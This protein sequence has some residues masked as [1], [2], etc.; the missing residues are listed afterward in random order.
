MN[1]NNSTRKNN[2]Q[3]GGKMAT[4]GS[5]ASVFSGHALHTSGGL[6]RK[7]LMRTKRGR[8]VS[9]KQHFSGL[10]AIVR[11]RKA[12]Y[13]TRKGKFALFKKQ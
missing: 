12:G 8:I 11:L 1:N 4:V 5:K 6:T 3:S 13:V 7:N 10:K 2:N 9:K